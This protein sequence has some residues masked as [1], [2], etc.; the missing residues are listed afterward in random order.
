MLEILPFLDRLETRL[1]LGDPELVG[2]V[3]EDAHVGLGDGG[4][5]RHGGE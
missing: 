2:W 4:C 1:G 5:G 3:R